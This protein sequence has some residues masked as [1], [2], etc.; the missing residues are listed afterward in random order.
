MPPDSQIA[1]DYKPKNAK[2]SIR[3]ARWFISG[4]MVPIAGGVIAYLLT[5]N[6][7]QVAD[8]VSDVQTLPPP[9][10]PA[11]QPKSLEV[12]PI[13][14]PLGDTMEFVVRRNDTLDVWIDSGVSHTAVMKTRPELG[15]GTADV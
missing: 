10:F 8:Q 9:A 11:S 15:G 7:T 14:Q 5:N 12:A 4:L 1:F 2:S 13:P 3:H 6:P